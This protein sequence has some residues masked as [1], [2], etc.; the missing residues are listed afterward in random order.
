[1]DIRL[2]GPM[3]VLLLN[4]VLG[5]VRFVL[6]SLFDMLVQ[7]KVRFFTFYKIDTWLCALILCQ[8]SCVEHV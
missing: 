8:F 7:L 6:P 2:V 3:S 4:L 1:M 5:K